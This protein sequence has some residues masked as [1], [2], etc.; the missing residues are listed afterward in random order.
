MNEQMQKDA[1]IL[2]TQKILDLLRDIESNPAVTQRYLA[3]KHSI[4]LGKINF[5]LKALLDRG[6]IKAQRFKNS[7]NKAAY[8]YILT[9]EGIQVRFQYT[10]KFLVQKAQEYEDLK[11]DLAVLIEDQKT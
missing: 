5:L 2:Y 9:P 10:K 1:D 8:A 3:E 11:R 7:K 4:S 6:V